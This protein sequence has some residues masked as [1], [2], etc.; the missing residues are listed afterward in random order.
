MED[1]ADHDDLGQMLAKC[2]EQLEAQRPFAGDMEAT[3][4]VPLEDGSE[5]EVTVTRK[6]A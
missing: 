1:F 3:F 2:I 5:Y 4:I 6:A